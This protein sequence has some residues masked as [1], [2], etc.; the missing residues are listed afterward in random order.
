MMLRGDPRY[1][2]YRGIG[3]IVVDR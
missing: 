2:R 1:P 3:T